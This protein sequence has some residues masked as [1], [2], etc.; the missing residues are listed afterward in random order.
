MSER[1]TSECEA[2]LNAL[3]ALTH[4]HLQGLVMQGGWSGGG[5][6]LLLLWW[7]FWNWT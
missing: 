4:I 3:N 1:I 6:L 5:T 7:W 2:Q